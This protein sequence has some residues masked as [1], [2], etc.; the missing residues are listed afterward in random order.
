MRTF[1]IADV[2]GY[3]RFSDTRGD[4]AA[5]SLAERFVAVSREGVEANAGSI[6]EVRGDEILA[7][8]ELARQAVRAA[9]DL[10][11]AFATEPAEGMSLG[12]GIGIDAG[13]AVALAGG[14]RGRALNMA[15]RLCARARPGEILVTPELA[16]LAGAIEGI[17]FDDRGQVRLKG[18]SR[19]VGLVS[20]LGVSAAASTRAAPAPAAGNVEFRLLGPVEALEDGRAIPLGGPRQRLVLAHLL[21]SANRVLSM[22]ELV[23]R[24]WDGEP[25]QAARN[26]IQSYVSHLRAALGVDRIEGRVPGYVL[27]AEPEQLDILRFEQLLRQARRQ[28]ATE[29]REAVATFGEALELW[30]GSPM[31]DFSDA[32]SLAGEIT[33]LQ[34]LRLAA[35][36]DVLGARLAIGEHAEALPDLERITLEHPMRERLWAHLLLARYRSGRQAEA[37]EGYRRAQEILGEELGIDPSPELQDLHRRMLQ[38]DPALQLSGRPLRG[39]RLLERVGQGEFGIVW[40]G[41]DPDL[42]REVAVK[43]IHPKLANDSR[44][45]RRFE[46]EAQT[47]A[48]LEHPHVVPLY[49]Y[50]R[51]G[52]GAYLVMR[53]MRGGSLEEA[54][55]RGPL[56]VDQTAQVVDQVAAALFAAHRGHTV[57]RDVKP[58]NI[59]LDEDGNAYLADFGI[60]LNLTD[61]GDGLS[62]AIAGY[63]SPEQLRGEEVGPRS[64]IYSLGM[65]AQDLLNGGGAAGPVADVLQR[66]TADD[67][68]ERYPAATEFASALRDALGLSAWPRP[69]KPVVEDRNPYKGLHPFTEADTDDFFGRDGLVD[70]L[71]GRLAEQVEGSRFLAVIGPSG[72]GKSSVVRAGL[73]PTLRRGALLGSERWLYVEMLPGAHPMEELEVALLRVAVNPPRSLLELLERDDEGLARVVPRLL[74]DD[75]TELVLVI[76][77]LEEVFTMVEGDDTRD[78]FLRSVVAAIRNPRSHLRVVATLRADFYDRPLAHPGL[79]ELMRVRSETVVPLTPEELERAIAGPAERVGVAPQ[80]SLVAE[81]VADVS[82]RPGALPLLQY[83]LT[84]LF[85]RRRDDA[86]TLE[87]YRE[88]DGIA[89]ALAR[90]AEELYEELDEGEQEAV[91]QLFLRLV[92]PGEGRGDTR[93]LVLRSELLNLQVDR[94]AI[95]RVIEVYG[96][97]RLLSFDRD[98]TTRGPTIEVAHEALLGSWERLRIWIDDARDDLRQHHRLSGAATDWDASGRDPSL[99]LR[100]ARLKELEAWQTST[101]LALSGDEQEYLGA[102]IRQ[103]D[104]EQEEEQARSNRERALQRRSLRRARALVAVLT[105][106]ALVAAGLTAV[107]I[108]RTGEA[109]R[110][111]DEAA[112]IGLTGAALSTLGTDPQSS[113][114]LALYA[115]DESL[116]IGQ[117]VPAETVEALHWAIQAAGIAYPVRDGPAVPVAGP[118]GTRG[119][120]DLPVSDLANLARAHVTG[121]LSESLCRRFFG[122]GTCPSIRSFPT[123]IAAQAIRPAQSPIPGQPLAGTQVLLGVFNP[124]GQED[125]QNE[126]RVFTEKTG[127]GVHLVEVTEFGAGAE[128]GSVDG[129]ARPDLGFTPTPNEL[130]RAAQSGALIDLNTYL[131][132]EQLRKDQSPHLL[133]LGTVARDGTWPST[134]GG[135]YGAFISL[136]VKNTVW[137]PVPEFRKAGYTIPRTWDELISLSDRMVADGRDPWCL[138]FLSDGS[139]G[140]P[141]TDWV[142]S[143]LLS[144]AGPQ[145]YDRW[146][147]HQIPFDSASVRAAFQRLGSI[148]FTD[149]YVHQVT[150]PQ[151]YWDLAFSS[152]LEEAPPG[153]WLYRAPSFAAGLFDPED[154]G[155]VTDVFSLPAVNDAYDGAA[156]GGGIMVSAFA[157]RPEV[158]EL[159]RFFVSPEYGREWAAQGNGFISANRRFDLQNYKPFWRGPAKATYD[160]LAADLF[161]F[162]ASDLMPVEVG[163]GLF[164][165]AML[166]YL[167]QGPHSLEGILTGLD[168]AWPDGG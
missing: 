47:I 73:I 91:K 144:E 118:F 110:R 96:R 140:W 18:I 159:M 22:E 121:R 125:L 28:I 2:R 106:A 52:T 64:D 113:L 37:L 85:E 163:S 90:R 98:P 29:P 41:L 152:M 119:V 39:Y 102:S 19:P 57:H 124:R 123:G 8:F 137:Y 53:W 115:V 63:Q 88:I 59:L 1:L 153:C 66:A 16:H 43:Q 5:A 129:G 25:P 161:R 117:P 135:L 72:S 145:A 146:A 167:D 62:P 93:R 33:R 31:S 15:A 83:A 44:F 127:I 71:V 38:Q 168:D 11:A 164:W 156:V 134:E 9:V 141:G 149:G 13:E 42:G 139:D 32:P 24:V 68:G 74:P 12:V 76:D 27:H 49:D 6:V 79:A 111:R 65:V 97:H 114:Q 108:N 136:D 34:Q 75:E 46:Q 81:M 138:G 158:R 105:A 155:K 7:V 132:V 147:F 4:E 109:E 103:R 116:S 99:L 55:G 26:T 69:A 14:Y 143:L 78:R 166:T 23:D 82:D 20:V 58:S 100:G 133:S 80:R 107:A 160:A 21:L 157:D 35:I 86:L 131:E 112:I 17:R 126:L 89:G 95:E 36:E 150:G 67:P 151:R 101:D 70:R 10:Q 84:E 165:D 142:E 3:T 120:F 87:A 60:A 148:L 50:W 77:Q 54:I 30:R 128:G 104:Q 40:R 154:L 51:D 45:V 94:R 92:I 48:R 130:Q 122:A 162:D 56:G 61:W